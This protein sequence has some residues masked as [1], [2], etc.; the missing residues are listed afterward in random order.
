VANLNR[1]DF[2]LGLRGGT[3]RSST[4][5]FEAVITLTLDVTAR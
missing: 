1:S 2:L 5:D 4:G 3:P